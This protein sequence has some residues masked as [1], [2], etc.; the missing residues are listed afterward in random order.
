MIQL[1]DFS[2]ELT[3]VTDELHIVHGGGFSPLDTALG[4]LAG[5]IGGGL[6]QGA[7]NYSVGKPL[8]DGVPQSIIVNAGFGAFNPVSGMSSFGLGVS[9]A[10]GGAFG[11]PTAIDGAKKYLLPQ[12]GFSPYGLGNIKF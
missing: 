12:G 9:K 1:N 3:E 4:G 6:G 7:Y 5:G 10:T 2:K 11:V 8:T